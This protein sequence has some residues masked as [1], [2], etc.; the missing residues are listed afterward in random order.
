M[1]RAL[2]IAA[3]LVALVACAAAQGPCIECKDC[4]T[5]NCRKQCQAKCPTLVSGDQCKKDGYAIGKTVGAE[6][7][8]TTDLYCNGGKP[9]MTPKGQ[10]SIGG[11]TPNQCQNIAYGECQ[12]AATT[13]SQVPCG[14]ALSSGAFQC[15]AKTYKDFYVG[16]INELCWKLIFE[17]VKY[18]TSG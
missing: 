13:P 1:A 2:L 16:E 9:P 5:D 12:V 10:R 7:C 14:K 11:V 3:A 8:K 18:N 4:K 6:A 15:N 17:K